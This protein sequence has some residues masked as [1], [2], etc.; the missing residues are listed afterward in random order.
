MQNL[1][2]TSKDT[3]KLRKEVASLADN[4]TRLN[5]IYGNML[6]AMATAVLRLIS[7]KNF[8]QKARQ[9]LHLSIYR[10]QKY[11]ALP[12]CLCSKF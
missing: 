10:I 8:N 12:P 2:D 1:L 9:M 4:M 11:E 5:T 3:D 6:T 7:L